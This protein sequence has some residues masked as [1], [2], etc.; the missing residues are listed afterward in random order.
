MDRLEMFKTLMVMA[1]AD[2]KFSSEEIELLAL[3]SH[4]WGLSDEQFSESLEFAKSG[5]E[6][7]NFPE[8]NE[9]R[10]R[11]LRDLLEVMAADGEL[12]PVEK[13]LYA[14]A[15]AAMGLSADDLDRMIDECL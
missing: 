3:R 11:L 15:A 12:A 7:L 1:A 10:E 2:G 13:K 4:R 8:S 5:A 14:L 6:T 9:A